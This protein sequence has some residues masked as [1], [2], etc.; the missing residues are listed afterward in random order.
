MT[1][2]ALSAGTPVGRYRLDELVSRGGMGEVW[3]AYDATL[4]RSVAVKLLH[5]GVTD[6]GDRER[7]LREARAAAQLSHP[8]IVSIFD[9]GEWNGRPF[10]VMELL[11]GR[12]LA[13][14]LADR[15][16]LPLEAVRDLGAQAAA[17]LSAAH[18]AGIVHRDIKPSNLVHTQDGTLKLVDFGIARVLDEASTRLTATGTIVGTAA[19]LAPEQARGLASDTR[20]D[21]YALGCVLYQLLSG[22]TPF[23]GGP[24]EVMYAHLYTTPEPP[25]LLR[26]DVPPDLE[27][28]V[29][30]MLAKDPDLRPQDAA[31]VRST[32]LASPTAATAFAPAAG[33][34]SGQAAPPWHPD[35]PRYGDD[36][37]RADGRGGGTQSLPVEEISGPGDRLDDEPPRRQ[38][39]RAALLLLVGIAAVAL[40][41]WGGTTW[42]N[43][44]NRGQGQAG[45][46]QPTAPAGQQESPTESE[47]PTPT[48]N[49]PA[50]L[51]P[52]S[53][54]WLRRLRGVI[55]TLAAV[56]A[57]DPE[58][59]DK[60]RGKIDDA[61]E[62]YAEGRPNQA[63]KKVNDLMRDI[64]EAREDGDIAE[65]T[66]LDEVVGGLDVLDRLRPD[67]DGDGGDGDNSGPGNGDGGDGGGRSGEG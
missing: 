62:N 55:T 47:T 20:T 15:G 40:L 60:L 6:R 24:T 30:A 1:V 64:R 56:D 12:T 9:V 58:V 38:P 43:S 11:N 57:I 44:V 31:G 18:A 53:P 17:G 13:E 14:E 7:F 59:A 41:V 28:M 51:E 29:L 35:S 34:L 5:E 25:S 63:R 16:P 19:Y 65:G 36:R 52:G 26:P 67:G 48:A 10:L 49:E 27:A 4:G 45:N 3:R 21:L 46:N 33:A 42:W 39:V 8:N 2:T 32:L 22:R 66:R 54:D 50:S 37:S 61:L 23:V